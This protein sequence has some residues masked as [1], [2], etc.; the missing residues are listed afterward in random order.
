[1]AAVYFYWMSR[2]RSGR[3]FRAID[4]H[5]H[6]TLEDHATEARDLRDNQPPRDDLQQPTLPGGDM[7]PLT[8]MLQFL[9]EERNRR[10][11]ARVGGGTLPTRGRRA[12]T[13]KGGATEEAERRARGSAADACIF[14]KDWC[15]DCRNKQK[16]QQSR[17]I[18]IKTSTDK[19]HRKR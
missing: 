11:H 9:I 2:T 17:L 3:V 16:L 13:P 1:M 18:E 12:T 19:T 8:Q 7:Q 14:Y 15:K 10:D 4:Q 5:Q 6:H